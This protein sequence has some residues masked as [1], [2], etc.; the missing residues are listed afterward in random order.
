[1]AIKRI[2]L[3]IVPL[4]LCLAD[5]KPP[6]PRPEPIPPPPEPK[7]ISSPLFVRSGDPGSIILRIPKSLIAKLRTENM[8]AI[9]VADSRLRNVLAAVFLSFGIVGI[10]YWLSRRHSLNPVTRQG[11]PVL[12]FLLLVASA[13]SIWG[14]SP[15]PG[16][17]PGAGRVFRGTL[18]DLNRAL[19]PAPMILSGN[20]SIEITP[21]GSA[22]ELIVPP[23]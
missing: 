21:E 16:Q 4:A 7:K 13:T 5:I 1:L 22:I 12:T 17:K 2:A 18:T 9:P 23:R 20:V 3:F 6:S 14:D 11:L 8:P 19:L 10:G 15:A